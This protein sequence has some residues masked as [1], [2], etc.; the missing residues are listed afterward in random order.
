MQYDMYFYMSTCMYVLDENTNTN[1]NSI[2]YAMYHISY[3][4][5]I[6]ESSKQYN[7]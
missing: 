2:Y 1:E 3:M 4:Y 7:M 6:G 5:D